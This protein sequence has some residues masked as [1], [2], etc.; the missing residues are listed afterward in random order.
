MWKQIITALMDAL[1]LVTYTSDDRK[2]R[3]RWNT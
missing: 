2:N 1:R 3:R